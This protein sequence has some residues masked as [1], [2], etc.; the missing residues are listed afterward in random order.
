MRTTTDVRPFHRIAVLTSIKIVDQITRDDLHHAT[1]CAGWDLGDLLAHMTVQHRGFAAAAR[2]AGA[3]LAVWDVDTVSEAVAVSPAATYAAAARDVIDAFAAD[4]TME[5]KFA[6]PEF[7]PDVVVPG[8]L[9]MGFHFID[10]VVHGWDVARSIDVD[11][12]LPA[13]VIAAAE[14]IAFAVPDDASRRTPR[15]PFR[16]ALDS[17]RG[18]SRLDRILAHLGRSPAWVPRPVRCA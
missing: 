15:S 12:Q 10:Y 17:P 6:L 2:G 16:T 18:S 11:F 7:G 14:P 9:A 4:G 5:A 13:D 3:D 1:P 8:A